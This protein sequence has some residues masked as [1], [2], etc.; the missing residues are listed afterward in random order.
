MPESPLAAHSLA[1][2]HLYA[3][4]SRCAS[5]GKGS[6][7]ATETKRLS[8][9]GAVPVLLSM[10]LE[11]VVCGTSRNAVFQLAASPVAQNPEAGA[12]VNPTD[13]PSRILDVGQWITLFQM[14]TEAASKQ[15]DK[16]EIRHLGLEAALCLEEALRFYDDLENDLP[17]PNAIFNEVS[18]QTF[19]NHPELFSK[20]RLIKLRQKLPSLDAMRSILREPPRRRWWKR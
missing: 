17:P 16:K 5:C 9:P 18:R 15:L 4:V 12:V 11:C 14:I 6:F 20:T 1:E 2:A 10:P 13:E 3:M 8:E 7:R 19:R